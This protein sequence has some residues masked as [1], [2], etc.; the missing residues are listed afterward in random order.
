MTYGF[1]NG[2]WPTMVTPFKENGAIDYDALA[3]L[4]DWYME[5]GADGLFSTCQSSEIFF[6][7]L[8]E[9]VKL[10]RF[11]KAH[12]GGRVPVIASGHVSHDISDQ[13]N[14]LNAIAECGADAV[15]LISNRL[16][17]PDEPDSVLVE[18]LDKIV[19]ALP[20]EVPLGFYECPY[21]YK[22]VLTPEVIRYCTSSGRFY[23]LKDTCCDI[24]QIKEKLDLLNGS[25]MH[26]YNANTATLVESMKLGGS[27]YSG[28]MANFQMKLYSWLVK[29]WKDDPEITDEVQSILTVCSFVEM[30]NYPAN[31]KCFLNLNGVKMRETA[32]K[33]TQIPQNATEILELKQILFLTRQ[34]EKR[35]G[36]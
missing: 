25:N 5:N 32:R 31:A 14:E 29:H 27:G 13:I 28:V 20:K 8:D 33:G 11:V 34:I 18:R 24:A 30:K 23:F 3:K 35:L 21:P 4:T 1:S 36:I 9:R 10:T 15:I 22:R 12:S 7:S 16:A 2:A 26:L 6:L 17:A 19:N